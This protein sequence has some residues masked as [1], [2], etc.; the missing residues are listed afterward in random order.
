MSR[1]T[2]SSDNPKERPV[3]Y[4]TLV[5]ERRDH[6]AWLTLNRPDQLNAFD[7]PMIEAWR[8]ALE[9]AEAD[10][11]V[12]VIVVTGAGRAVCASGDC[13]ERAKMIE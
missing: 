8:A 13:G 4:D 9:A 11:R 12:K 5:L 1:A 7:L 3:T 6:I 10:D 2:G